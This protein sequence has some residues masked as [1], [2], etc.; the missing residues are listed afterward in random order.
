MNAL[1]RLTRESPLLATLGVTGVGLVAVSFHHWKKG[2]I[3]IGVGLLVGAALRLAL[4]ARRVGLLAVRGRTADVAVL[5]G[6]GLAIVVLA[7]I[8]PAVRVVPPP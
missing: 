3:V 2:L 6:L 4:P 1:D 8:V 7:L 5:A